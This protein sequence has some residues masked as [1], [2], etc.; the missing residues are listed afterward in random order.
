MNGVHD[1]GGL[2][3]YGP[4]HI[5]LHEP[6]FHHAWERRALGV[7]VAMGASGLW[8]IDLARSARESLPPLDYVQGPYYAIWTKALQNLLIERGLITAQELALGQ[9][10]TPPMAGVRVLKAAEVD[11]ALRK[12]SPTD[13]PNTQAPGFTV[14]QRVR[15]LNLNPPGHTRLPRYV[16]GHVGTVVLHHGSHVL[17][18]RHVNTML[19]PFDSSAEHLYTV[20]FDGTELWGPQAEAGHQVSVDAWESY[21]EAV[22]A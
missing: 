4:V 5:E 17:P 18:D 1:M 6:L 12:G 9:P 10:I 21:L 3:G 8:N 11:A 13:R 7:T 16:R 2:Q 20:V 15:A 19:A 22:P 14:G